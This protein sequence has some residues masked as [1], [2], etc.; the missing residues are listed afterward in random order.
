MK[1]LKYIAKIEG[2]DMDVLVDEINEFIYSMLLENEY[3]IDIRIIKI[4]EV[5]QPGEYYVFKCKDKKSDLMAMLYIGE[6]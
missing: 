2:S 6:E 1:D 5:E 4:G 3:I